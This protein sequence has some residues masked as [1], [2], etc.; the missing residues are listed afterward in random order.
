MASSASRTMAPGASEWKHGRHE[1][2]SFEVDLQGDV[3]EIRLLLI[4]DKSWFRSYAC[5]ASITMA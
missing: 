3:G 4:E 5:P 1:K 2:V